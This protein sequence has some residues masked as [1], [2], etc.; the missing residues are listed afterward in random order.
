MDKSSSAATEQRAESCPGAGLGKVCQQKGTPRGQMSDYM[1]HLKL[2]HSYVSL[3][4]QFQ[5]MEYPHLGG[6]KDLSDGFNHMNEPA[7]DVDLGEVTVVE[8]VDSDKDKMIEEL[9][10]QLAEAS[11]NLEKEKLRRKS[12]ENPEATKVAKI[13]IENKSAIIEYDAEHDRVVTKDEDELNRLVEEHCKVKKDKD[14][15][16]SLMRNQ[17]LEKVRIFE[18][19]RLGLKPS[20]SRSM[21]R[22]RSDDSDSES[23]SVKSLRLASS[24]PVFTDQ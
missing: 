15:N 13:V 18:R 10:K 5:T 9:K 20:R 16:L 4:I 19:K 11:T 24:Q 8:K 1:R 7:D 2:Q 3:K 6:Q 12:T 17:V 14:K 22:G 21:L 23:G